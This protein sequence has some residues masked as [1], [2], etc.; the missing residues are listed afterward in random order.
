MIID[1][2]QAYPIFLFTAE[3]IQDGNSDNDKRNYGLEK[4]KI[5]NS[6]SFYKMF[7]EEGDIHEQ[8]LILLKWWDYYSKNKLK[9][10]NPINP[11]L[12]VKLHEWETWTI[13]W[14][15]HE[16]F[17]NGQSDIEV[18]NSFEKFVSRK[19]ELNLEYK[20]K[21]GL[22]KFCL[23]GAEDRWRWHGESNDS[24]PPCRCSHCKKQ[25]MIRISH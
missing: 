12:N 25:G 23:M 5:W 4:G 21:T 9:D 11:L 22:D 14:F 15:C 6:T 3:W 18:L 24:P 2:E 13:T 20:Y 19:E 7:K 10:K 8:K 16:T 17:D 1:G